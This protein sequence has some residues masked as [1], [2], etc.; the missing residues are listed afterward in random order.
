MTARF[1]L[2][3]SVQR[4]SPTTSST[5]MHNDDIMSSQKE[6]WFKMPLLELLIII[7]ALDLAAQRW[8]ADSRDDE[9]SPEWIHRWQRGFFL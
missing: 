2:G 3:C 5:Q 6:G 1:P 8:G 4:V 9:Q 7:I